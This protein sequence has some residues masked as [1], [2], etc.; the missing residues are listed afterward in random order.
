MKHISHPI[1][2]DAKYGRGRHNRYFSEHLNCPRL[3]LAATNL[4]FIHPYTN[5]KLSIS[6]DPGA[7]FRQTCE[8]INLSTNNLPISGT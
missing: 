7:V 5:Q 6:A 8:A 3:L 4:S 1:I 2:G